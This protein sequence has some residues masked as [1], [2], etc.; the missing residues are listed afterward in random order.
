MATE[1][2]LEV[3]VNSG[4]SVNAVK[5]LKKEIRDLESLSLQ[6]AEAGN[7][8]LARKYSA[9]AGAAKDKI[10]D[11]KAEVGAL[12][13]AG[14]KLGT[15]TKVAAGIAQGFAAAQG[16]A[17][18]FGSSGKDLEKVLLKVQAA[19]ALAQGIQGIATLQEEF[20]R[21]KVVALDAFKGIRA[22]IGSTGIGLLVVA[23]GAIVVYW[24]DIKALV[25]GVSE[26]Q[27]KLNE[28]TNKNLKI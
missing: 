14:S 5:D 2:A 23:L 20:G 11:L 18:L 25:S 27:N 26:E 6:A 15:I 16:A 21:M 4:S 9:A 8:A 19:S 12:S 28:E 10:S 24:D 3:K 1:I 17:A 22:A 7:N 13:D